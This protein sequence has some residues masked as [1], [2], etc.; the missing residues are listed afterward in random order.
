[1]PFTVTMPPGSEPV[2]LDELKD[3]LRIDDTSQDDLLNVLIE[4][5]RV[6][7]EQQTRRAL[8]TQTVTAVFADWPGDASDGLVLPVGNA[9]A[10]SSVKYY[11]ADNTQQT[12][13][14]ADYFLVAATQ[15]A[16]LIF[17]D[18]FTSPDVFDREDAVEVVF[19]AGF[20][21]SAASV[22]Q[23]LKVAVMGLA[24]YWFEQRLPVNV[25]NIV[26]PMPLHVQ[27]MINAYR[28]IMPQE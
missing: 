1:M 24:A 9:A 26:N 21:A 22:P 3:Y 8:I 13:S 15:P 14:S 12:V 19:T 6:R 18:A 4:A 10:I 20:G 5:A 17:K 25:G 28:V 2:T 27:T 23:L 16:R 7:V 11:D